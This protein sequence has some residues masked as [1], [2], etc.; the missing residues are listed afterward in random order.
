MTTLLDLSSA[1][2]ASHWSKHSL[3]AFVGCWAT[4]S[5]K[6]ENLVVPSFFV[7]PSFTEFWRRSDAPAGDRSPV[8][9]AAGPVRRP[10]GFA[11][12]SWAA[13][14]APAR[15]P[16]PAA[17]APLTELPKMSSSSFG[18]APRSAVLE[19]EFR[20]FPP[21]FPVTTK[22]AMDFQ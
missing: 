3:D 16:R 1:P 12:T 10:A 14:V 6:K 5:K 11:S 9:S 7:L 2:L 21:S 20:R 18:D 15:R 8:R 19:R 13:P 22:M 17:P 4:E